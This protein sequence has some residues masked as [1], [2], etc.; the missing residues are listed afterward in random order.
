M[1]RVELKT[2]NNRLNIFLYVN[3]IND[4]EVETFIYGNMNF[5]VNDNKYNSIY[6]DFLIFDFLIPIKNIDFIKSNKIVL[7][8]IYNQNKYI[9]KKRE[10]EINSR[11]KNKINDSIFNSKNIDELKYNNKF[12][13]AVLSKLNRD[14]RDDGG[15]TQHFTSL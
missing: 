13:S 5:T 15:L 2:I 4:I 12:I 6:L 10:F 8:L 7:F 11:I 9:I 3:D 14:I 1:N